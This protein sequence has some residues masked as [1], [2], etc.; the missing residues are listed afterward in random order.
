[1][2]LASGDDIFELVRDLHQLL[3]LAIRIDSQQKE[4][5][6]LANLV[7]PDCTS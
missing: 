5:L 6:K 2:V 7:Y 4:A 3:S 1:M